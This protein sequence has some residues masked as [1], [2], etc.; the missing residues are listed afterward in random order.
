VEEGGSWGRHVQPRE[1]LC[2]AA[3]HGLRAARG[4]QA[5]GRREQRG[6]AEVEELAMM[7]L[8]S[9]KRKR[10]KR[11]RTKKTT[12][13]SSLKRMLLLLMLEEAV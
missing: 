5:F 12:T 3:A 1:G 2:P 4:P 13:M 10:M 11:M 9:M 7:A 8:M 6:S